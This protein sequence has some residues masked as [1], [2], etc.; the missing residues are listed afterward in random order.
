[1]EMDEDERPQERPSFEDRPDDEPEEDEKEETAD[2]EAAA[3][4]RQP[5]TVDRRGAQT[6]WLVSYSDFMTILMIFFLAMYGYT[7]LA[8]LTLMKQQQEGVTFEEF[9]ARVQE[10]KKSLGNNMQVQEDTDKLTI[11]LGE[12]ILFTSGSATL[13]A[14][15]KGTLEELANSVKLVQG[16]VIVQGHTDNVPIRGGRFKSNWELSAARAFSV[17]QELTKDGVEPKRLGAWGFGENRPI[18]ENTTA[19]G[20]AENRRIE[21]MVLKK[22]GNA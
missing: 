13:N 2:E 20:R 11:Q 6:L 4:K 19:E 21:V 16:D 3:P 10:L 12:K 22:K 14:A 17:V 7:Y 1:M 18:S 5:P 9:S 15:A 8:K